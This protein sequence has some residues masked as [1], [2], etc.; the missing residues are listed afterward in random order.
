MAKEEDKCEEGGE[1]KEGGEGQKEDPSTPTEEV[2][3]NISSCKDGEE[4]SL[5][6]ETDTKDESQ[7]PPE[8]SKI[9]DCDS[10]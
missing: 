4:G 8:E 7:S 1:D 9:D 6:V 3:D 5:P 10:V 2:V